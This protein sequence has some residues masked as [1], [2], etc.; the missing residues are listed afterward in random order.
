VQNALLEQGGGCRPLSRRGG[1]AV[2]SDAEREKGK[3]RK[4]KRAGNMEGLEAG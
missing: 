2:E 3:E 4:E 1:K